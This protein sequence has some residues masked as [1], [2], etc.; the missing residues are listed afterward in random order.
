MP[1][2][3]GWLPPNMQPGDYGRVDVEKVLADSAARGHPLKPDHPWTHWECCA[4]DG[5]S[6]RLDPTIHTVIEHEDG[7][8]T[9]TPSIDFSKR[10]PGGW[11]GHLV[12]GDGW[13]END[14]PVFYGHNRDIPCSACGGTGERDHQTVF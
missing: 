2:E 7:T 12:R 13:M 8:I 1:L 6:G 5:S 11:H 10:K 14:D 4:P 9:V 3:S